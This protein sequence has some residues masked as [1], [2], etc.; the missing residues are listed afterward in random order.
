MSR[1]I[2]VSSGSYEKMS[3][4]NIIKENKWLDYL[5]LKSTLPKTVYK[6]CKLKGGSQSPISDMATWETAQ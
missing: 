2:I 4:K 5:D 3:V 6:S 1:K